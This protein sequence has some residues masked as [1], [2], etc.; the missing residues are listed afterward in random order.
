MEIVPPSNVCHAEAIDKDAHRRDENVEEGELGRED[1]E[2]LLCLSSSC[3][4]LLFTLLLFF[5]S[6]LCL[7]FGAPLA[8]LCAGGEGE[9]GEGGHEDDGGV[10]DEGLEDATVPAGGET[11]KEAGEEYCG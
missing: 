11:K 6:L 3:L 9:V 1:D 7:L 4:A 5:I 2:G 10:G 8:P